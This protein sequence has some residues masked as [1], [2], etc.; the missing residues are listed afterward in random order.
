[1]AHNR[2]QS[3][4]P[5]DLKK[6]LGKEF[7]SEFLEVLGA[8]PFIS[9]MINS[10]RPRVKDTAKDAAGRVIV[11]LESPHILED[12]DYFREAAITFD[13][14]GKYTNILPNGHPGSEY[15]KFWTEE[16]R[17]CRIGMMRKDGEWVTGLNYFYWNYSPI[18]LV[19]DEEDDT[20]EKGT[21]LA[22]R[23]EGFPKPWD[24]DYLY[25]HYIEK[26][27]RA[28]KHGNVLKA[29]G[30]GYS[31]KGG[32]GLAKYFK[33]GDRHSPKS[34]Q[35]KQKVFAIANEKE[36]LTKDGVLNKF[37]DNVTFLDKH[38][39]WPRAKLK[40]SLND[41]HWRLGYVDG[42]SKDDAGVLNEV[43]GVSLKND[44]QKARGKRGPYIIWEE[45][46]KFPELLTAWAI[47][48]PSVESGNR[49]FGC[50]VAYGTGGTDE[51]DFSSAE[52]LFYNPNGYN[53]LGL[54]N[55]FDRGAG[56]NSICA[57]FSPE[58]LNREDCYDKDGNSDI[59]KAL[60]E[61]MVSRKTV[62]Y[63]S[64]DPNALTQA[65]AEAPITPQEAVLR[66]GGTIF[67]VGD[68]KD[69]LSDISVNEAQFTASHY[70]GRLGVTDDNKARFILDT[71]KTPIREFPIKDNL[72]KE[73]CLEIFQLPIKNADGEVP[74]Y[75]YI[76]GCDTYDDDHSTTTSLGSVFIMDRITDSIV[77]EYTGRP[78]TANEF[79]EI[80]FRLGKFYNAL[81]N[82][83]NDK[84]G[85]FA[86]FS[87]RRGMQYLCDTPEILK[88]L[89]MIKAPTLYGNKA[90][91]TNSGVQIN[92][93]GRRLQADWLLEPAYG[94][95]EDEE[96]EDVKLNMHTI[97]S[98]G[99]IK[100]LIYWNPDGNF[101]R[102]SAMGM[103]MILREDMLTRD[104]REFK[105]RVKTVLD[106]PFF[107]RHEKRLIF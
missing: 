49:A 106:D 24:G 97:R 25:F 52:E 63:G 14:T 32:S 102:V 43:I 87:T 73:G 81:I 46:G 72:N 16:A 22:V 105:Q 68:L 40:D 29:R 91:G 10:G 92:A 45:M 71:N 26:C 89:E 56:Q 82:Y 103:L 35:K 36:Y 48:R 61:V 94:E 104:V 65:K 98:I 5:D 54:K 55:V 38:T 51:A 77:A 59:I 100:E 3:R 67:P 11:D 95:L 86:Y 28:G 107:S 19:G 47:A 80:V 44:P 33:L 75:R 27:R 23:I 90:K 84:K 17:R 60:I 13:A 66:K 31:F 57:F 8:I 20:V 9:D 96:N 85:L 53:I 15:V 70:I 18:L 83:E 39:P 41:M 58:Y 64:S 30:R 2:C 101:D 6:T 69:F 74:R 34:S 79:Y 1:M 21:E 42:K 78:K 50:M 7:Y 99:Y 62:K 37:V 76:G 4:V 93:L 12:M 88:S